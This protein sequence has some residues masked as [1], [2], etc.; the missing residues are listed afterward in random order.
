LNF[1]SKN[2]PGRGVGS[3][4]SEIDSGLR[5]RYEISRKFAPHIGVAYTGT[6]GQAATFTREEGGNPND[7]RFIFG[8]RLWY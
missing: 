2:D 5:I 6:F 1:Y 3:G 7:P 8:V 4:L